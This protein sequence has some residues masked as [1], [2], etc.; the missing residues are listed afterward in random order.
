[1]QRVGV[2]SILGMCLENDTMYLAPSIPQSWPGLGMTV[3]FGSARYG[4]VVERSN[5]VGQ[6]IMPRRWTG[7]RPKL[8]R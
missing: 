8:F 4:I 2:E 1:M 3:R 7:Q 6:G 5:S